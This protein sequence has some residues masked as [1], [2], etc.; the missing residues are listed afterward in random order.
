MVSE[1]A[2]SRAGSLAPVGG[3]LALDFANTAA[4]RDTAGPVEHLP[5]AAHVVDWAAHAGAIDARAARRIRAGLGRD[6]DAARKVLRLAL[7]LREAVYRIGAAVARG[8][9]PAGEDLARLKEH[10]RRALGTAGLGPRPGGGYAFDF[11]AAPA[12]QALLG[13]IA[14]SAVDLL[15]AGRLDRV[16]QC[17]G[18]G[19]G[20]LF[21][22]QS[23]NGSRRWCDMATCG[24]RSKGRRHRARRG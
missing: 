15:A 24:N 22:D 10:A 16:K 6:R 1:E 20:W 11:S 2:A 23:K 18:P 17:P 5:S 4:G 13:P 19:C 12:E 8:E 7:D 9:A 21:L 14:W 3:V